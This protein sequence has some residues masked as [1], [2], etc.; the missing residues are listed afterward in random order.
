M[1]HVF[2]A[3]GTRA[4][5]EGF[6][7]VTRRVAGFAGQRTVFSQQGE[8]CLIVVEVGRGFSELERSFGVAAFAVLTKLVLVYIDVTGGAI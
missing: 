2:V 3:I 5:F 1:F 8:S 7:H 6:R 4:V